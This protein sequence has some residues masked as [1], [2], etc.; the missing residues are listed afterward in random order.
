MLIVWLS[1]ECFTKDGVPKGI[2]SFGG[3]STI[4]SVIPPYPSLRSDETENKRLSNVSA[5]AAP[6]LESTDC[7]PIEHTD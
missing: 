4:W 5:A 6:F 7:A 1:V 3:K 2:S